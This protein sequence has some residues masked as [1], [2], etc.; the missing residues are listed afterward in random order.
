MQVVPAPLLLTRGP[1]AHVGTSPRTGSVGLK[2]RLCG[3]G[4]GVRAHG[5]H[6]SQET[7]LRENPGLCTGRGRGL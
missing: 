2:L 5:L 4:R 6:P 1:P 3:P 7:G